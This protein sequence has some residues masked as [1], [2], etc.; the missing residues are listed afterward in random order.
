MATSELALCSRVERILPLFTLLVLIVVVIT[1]VLCENTLQTLDASLD[2]T[3]LV[4]L[5]SYYL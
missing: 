2:L 1:S 5:C 3:R 4:Q